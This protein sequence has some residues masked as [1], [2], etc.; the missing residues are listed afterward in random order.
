MA[1]ALSLTSGPGGI[2]APPRRTIDEM[3]EWCWGWNKRAREAGWANWLYVSEDKE[4]NTNAVKVRTGGDAL[5]V[6]GV[7]NGGYPD[8]YKW[9]AERLASEFRILRYMARM[10][11]PESDFARL[12]LGQPGG[13]PLHIARK[14]QPA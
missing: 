5:D 4:T 9:D 7:I 12:K 3:R 2:A 13:K 14:Q 1:N 10:G 11:M 8:F 6:I